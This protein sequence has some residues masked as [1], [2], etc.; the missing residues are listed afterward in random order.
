[1]FIAFT[2]KQA[3]S[4]LRKTSLKNLAVR[5]SNPCLVQCAPD[6]TPSWYIL[7]NGIILSWLASTDLELEHSR[8]GFYLNSI[9]VTSSF[10]FRR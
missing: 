10:M 6:G 2:L 4:D 8:N 1:M 5:T 3:L 9:K 7:E